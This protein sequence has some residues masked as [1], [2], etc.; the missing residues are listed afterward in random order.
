M[1]LLKIETTKHGY[2]GMVHKHICM[3]IENDEGQNGTIFNANNG[4]SS[5]NNCIN[6]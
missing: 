4:T 5:A 2:V 3:N 6:N 1:Q